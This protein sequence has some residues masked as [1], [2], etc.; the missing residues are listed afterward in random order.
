MTT[1][2]QIELNLSRSIKVALQIKAGLGGQPFQWGDAER[3][4]YTLRAASLGV[5]LVTATAMK[6]RGCE[7][8][9]NARP[10]GRAYFAA[11]LR[12]YADLYV[13][14]CQ[15]KPCSPKEAVSK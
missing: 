1:P 8:K 5:T 9:R 11:P 7:L 12:R 10:V 15:C 2:S 14:E 13:L 4:N 3:K 6:K